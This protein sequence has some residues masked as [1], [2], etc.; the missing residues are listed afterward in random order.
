MFDAAQH[1]LE[2][3]IDACRE[4]YHDAS[5]YVSETIA[6]LNLLAP[7]K[8]MLARVRKEDIS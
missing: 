2:W 1:P 3:A 8:R 4:C 6:L 5:K 7:V